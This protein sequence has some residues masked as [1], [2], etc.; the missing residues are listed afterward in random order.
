MQARRSFLS[1]MIKAASLY[2]VLPM[3]GLLGIGSAKSFAGPAIPSTNLFDVKK[4]GAKGDGKNVES[5][6]INSAIDAAALAGGGT[7]Y[8][9]AGTYLSASI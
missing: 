5:P 6:A 2:P 7:V 3:T 8:F 9:P 4:F 1:Y